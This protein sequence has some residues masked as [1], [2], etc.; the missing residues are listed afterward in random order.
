MNEME[1]RKFLFL[2]VVLKSFF[3]EKRGQKLGCVLYTGVYYTGARIIH[4][5]ILYTGAYYTRRVLYTGKYGT[6]QR[7]ATV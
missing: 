2:V 6:W 5:H 1:K 4:G 3:L 7:K